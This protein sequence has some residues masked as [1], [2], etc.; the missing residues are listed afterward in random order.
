MNSRLPE[1]TRPDRN[2]GPG[3]LPSVLSLEPARLEAVVAECRQPVYRARQ[4]RSWLLR[5]RASSFEEMTD[6]PREFREALSKRLVPLSSRIA[7]VH[8]GSSGETTKVVLE[9]HDDEAIETVLIR[10]GGRRTACVSTQVGCPVACVFCASGLDGVRRNLESHEIVEQVLALQRALPAE[11]KI[12]NVVVMGSGEPLLNQAHLADAIRT[13]NDPGGFALG[14]RRMTVSTV[15]LPERIRRFAKFE[16]QVELAV[17][18]H[19]PTDPLRRKIIPGA[20]PVEEILAS[21]DEYTR[22]TGRQITFEYVLLDG[23]N[24]G[25]DTARDLAKLLRDR[26][27]L[28]NLIPHNPVPTVPYRAPDRARCQEF[29]RILEEAGIRSTLRKT[30]GQS[31]DAACGQ[32]RRVHLD[33]SQPP[34]KARS[35]RA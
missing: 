34:S 15:G 8:H 24:D 27:C 13:L 6:L 28:V 19:A 11:E 17:S 7:R 33:R 31:I 2:P 14:A 1:P 32:L 35:F 23:I 25:P 26:R 3:S 20:H 9:L 29:H 18:L 16:V 22:R 21:T 4:I 10:E 30:K 12:S 5:R